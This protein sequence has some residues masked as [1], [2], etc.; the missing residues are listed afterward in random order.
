MDVMVLIDVLHVFDV[1]ALEN[2]GL[3]GTMLVTVPWNLSRA[4]TVTST[5][6]FQPEGPRSWR[7]TRR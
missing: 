3:S 5:V 7:D 4:T 1:N 2:V 6:G